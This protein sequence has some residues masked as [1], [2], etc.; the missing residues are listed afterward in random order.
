MSRKG[1]ME[2]EYTLVEA[3]E[4]LGYEREHVRRLCNS[5]ELKYRREKT[6]HK[7]YFVKEES[8]TD[9]QLETWR[10]EQNRK[11]E[12]EMSTH[13]EDSVEL[14]PVMDEQLHSRVLSIV[15]QVVKPENFSIFNESDVDKLTKSFQE[16]TV[17]I[18]KNT[19]AVEALHKD[20]KI[21]S[22]K[23]PSKALSQ[24]SEENHGR[25]AK[26]PSVAPENVQELLSKWKQFRAKYVSGNV[27]GEGI[28][29]L[30]LEYGGNP[31]TER[32]WVRGKSK[33]PRALLD[34]V[35]RIL[36]ECGE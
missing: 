26:S 1:K 11:K 10:Q 16:M 25:S 23:S 24:K 34:V 29:P 20:I 36:E 32:D 22:H 18:T 17:A 35:K 9:L 31:R 12:E 28:G 13:V 6:G 8:F 27:K 30:L 19:Q 2:D 7:R 14:G 15:K 21:L 3:A 33:R 4:I 5:G